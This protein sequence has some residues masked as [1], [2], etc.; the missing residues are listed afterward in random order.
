MFVGVRQ[1]GGRDERKVKG[2]IR[3]GRRDNGSENR[4]CES[5]ERFSQT[6]MTMDIHEQPREKHTCTYRRMV[7]VLSQVCCDLLKGGK[8]FI[9]PQVLS[10]KGEYIRNLNWEK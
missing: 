8:I 6:L 5:L 1:E 7:H 2:R 10:T 9:F 4:K 3:S